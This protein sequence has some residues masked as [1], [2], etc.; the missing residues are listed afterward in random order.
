MFYSLLRSSYLSRVLIPPLG[1]YSSSSSFS[2]SH[3]L[4]TPHLSLSSISPPLFS[5]FVFSFLIFSPPF[6]S[7]F[8]FV[9][10]FSLTSFSPY[11]IFLIFLPCF[12][13]LLL[14][15][16]SSFLSFSLSLFLPFFL[17]FFLSFFLSLSPSLSSFP[18]HTVPDPLLPLSTPLPLVLDLRTTSHKALLQHTP[19]VPQMHWRTSR[20]LWGFSPGFAMT[21]SFVGFCVTISVTDQLRSGL[22]SLP[23][24]HGL[25]PRPS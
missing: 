1:S 24:C 21:P 10:S 11:S 19:P 18:P 3:D 23:M 8:A 15:H 20:A 5:F 6:L 9:I 25:T 7:S 12:I 2:P 22:A 13:F 17:P 16:V 14:L 4:I